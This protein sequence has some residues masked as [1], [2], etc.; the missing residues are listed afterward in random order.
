VVGRAEA[1][2]TLRIIFN[3]LVRVRGQMEGTESYSALSLVQGHM[4][5]RNG[6]IAVGPHLHFVVAFPYTYG[7]QGHPF[8][9]GS[10]LCRNGVSFSLFC[11]F[12]S[13]SFNFMFLPLILSP[14]TD[15]TDH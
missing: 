15:F 11:L 7:E 6:L 12:I 13:C 14:K 10:S 1:H 2:L 9:S 8:D 4:Q 3:W 5:T